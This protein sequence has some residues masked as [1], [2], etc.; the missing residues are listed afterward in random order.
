MVRM[1]KVHTLDRNGMEIKEVK[2]QEAERIF[3]ETYT[4]ALGGF[5]CD[6]RTGEGICELGPAAEELFVVDQIL[7]RG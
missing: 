2:L 3:K 6:K 4:D 5:V 1:I 7:G